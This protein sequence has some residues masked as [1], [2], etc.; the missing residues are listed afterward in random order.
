[1]AYSRSPP[2]SPNSQEDWSIRGPK[3]SKT[4]STSSRSTTQN[5]RSQSYASS[6]SR[7]FSTTGYEAVARA[8]HSE[9]H[10]YLSQI[11]AKEANEGTP[12]QR[13]SARQ[14]LSRLNPLQF[15]ELAMDVYDELIRRNRDDK[16]VP[17]LPVRDEFHPRR[18]QARQ[19][20][21]TLPISRFQDLASDVYS[22]LSRRYPQFVEGEEDV[23]SSPPPVPPMPIASPKMDSKPQPSQATNI[24]PVKGMINVEP[25]GPEED[26]NND[27]EIY[28][29]PSKS[30]G[31]GDGNFQSLDSLMADLGNM[32][33]APTGP[34]TETPQGIS[35]PERMRSEYEYRIATMAKRIQQLESEAAMVTYNDSYTIECGKL[36]LFGP[37]GSKESLHQDQ[38]RHQLSRGNDFQED[39]HRLEE[40]YRQLEHEH[41]EQQRTVQEVKTE[42]SKLLE[43]LKSLSAKNDELRTSKE[44][45]EQRTRQ[46]EDEVKEW[47]TKYESARQELR[48]IKGT[49]PSDE[50]QS[51]DI[52][53]DH[54]LQPTREG[55]I[56]HDHIVTYQTAIDAL[57]RS[58]RSNKPSEVLITMKTVVMA[59]KSL[60]E[61]VEA[62]ESSHELPALTQTKLYTL[63]TQFSDA[64]AQLLV[65][66]KNHANGMGIMPVGLIEGTAGH[67]TIVVVEL[68]KLLGISSTSETKTGTSAS[69]A[70]D[71]LDPEEL[72]EYLKTETDHIVQTI[73]NLLSALRSPGQITEVSDIIVSIVN[74]VSNVVEVSRS[75]FSGGAGLQYRKKGDLVLA[76]L[77]TCKDKLLQ[78]RDSSFA[79]SP[80]R[81]S[82]AAK[83]DLAKESYEIAKYTKELINIFED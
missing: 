81:A 65:A 82:A 48:N 45:A 64:L 36:K 1:M 56:A 43:E 72:S 76:D 37:Q 67:L 26:D 28:P 30:N 66:A 70:S 27:H 39:Y 32:V 53:K 19:K 83:R 77:L 51:Q 6:S 49:L 7:A 9:L 58:A 31:V 10:K 20:L 63:K 17:F 61:A 18:N 59:C 74:I 68:A 38:E 25:V 55:A 40:K 5:S 22:E 57:S 29:R 42:T 21:A 11:I 78:I 24:V 46:L 15:H 60:T 14:K 35:D 54:L 80:E 41:H 33:T 13:V 75:T 34:R 44:Q 4:F 12:P 3:P 2:Q 8:Y 71:R 16:Q 50:L 47:Q 79:Q 62:Y 52:M 69:T 23:Y 73:Q